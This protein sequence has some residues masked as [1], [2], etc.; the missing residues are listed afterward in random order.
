MKD[1][2]LKER[3]EL[4]DMWNAFMVDGATFTENDIPICPTFIPDGIPT[5]FISYHDAT[6]L[7]NEEISNG[8]YDYKVNKCIHFYIYDQYFDRPEDGIWTHP[9]EALDIINHFNGI[10]TPDF[11]T[12]LDFPHPIKIYNT[13]RM[14]AFG[15]W[16]YLNK[17][18]VINNVRWGTPDT[19]N[20][21]FDGIPHNSIISIGTVASGLTE[22]ENR[23]DF[24]LGLKKL[25][26]V[27]QPETVIIYGSSKYKSLDPLR[28]AG[29]NIVSI[30][31]KR[32]TIYKE[33]ERKNK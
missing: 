5:D 31:S 9:Y 12:F 32:N 33:G 23:T 25:I 26:S 20:Y 22:I 2:L 8:N 11:S 28:E 7:H 10:I 17:N 29:I 1:Y 16:M 18:P 21:S 27:V 3:K 19:W 30:P 6:I 24:E 4:V 14:R 15:H 13:Y